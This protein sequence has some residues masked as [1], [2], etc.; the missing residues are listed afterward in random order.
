[1]KAGFRCNR[2]RGWLLQEKTLKRRPS[3]LYMTE[4]LFCRVSITGDSIYGV[5]R[6]ESAYECFS[7]RPPS[8][9]GRTCLPVKIPV[10]QINRDVYRERLLSINDGCRNISPHL[11]ESCVIK[12]RSS[13]PLLRPLLSVDVVVVLTLGTILD[14]G[15]SQLI[16]DTL[17][18]PNQ[19]PYLLQSLRF[20]GQG[21]D[22]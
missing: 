11:S 13:K 5:P 12:D 4:L 6:V 7:G 2:H 18:P 15:S 9:I 17:S 16:Q 8:S 3:M 10:T 14:K 1:M 21:G 19:E 20:S 22:A